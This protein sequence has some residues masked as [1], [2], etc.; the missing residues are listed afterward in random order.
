MFPT[1][2][3]FK[4]EIAPPRQSGG[5]WQ[6]ADGQWWI[7]GH[8]T[9]EGYIVSATPG[10]FITSGVVWIDGSQLSLA[11]SHGWRHNGVRTAFG[12]N[13]VQVDRA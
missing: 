12:T 3:S 13:T 2:H 8:V 11:E 5:P 7:P 10:Q 6:S 4:V 1:G 9:P